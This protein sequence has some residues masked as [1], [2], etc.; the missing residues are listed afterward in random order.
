MKWLSVSESAVSPH[1]AHAHD[2]WVARMPTAEE[3]AFLELPAG[4]PVLYVIHTAR[5]EDGAVL[6]VAE[7]V[8]PAGRILVIDDYEIEADA[9]QPTSPSEV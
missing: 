3:A 8:W 6:E 7:S 1:R 5:A 9:E 4:A 2:Q